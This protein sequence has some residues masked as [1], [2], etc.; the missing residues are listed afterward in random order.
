VNKNSSVGWAEM[1]FNPVSGCQHPCRSTYCYNTMKSNGVLNRFGSRFYNPNTKSFETTMDW[2]SLETPNHSCFVAVK[3]ERY[4]HGYDPTFYPHRLQQPRSV[5]RLSQR[6]F[7]SDVGDLFGNWV[8]SQWIE[9]VIE[10]MTTFYW[11]KY[12]LLTKNPQRYQYFTFPD[13][14]WLGATVTSNADVNTLQIMQAINHPK[15]FLSVEPLFGPLTAPL[16]GINWVIVG[17]Q[18]GKNP[19]VPEDAWVNDILEEARRV[20]ALV[21]MKENLLKNYKGRRVYQQTP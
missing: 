2:K 15:K 21:Y 14:C 1:S 16:T 20:K 10:A 18:T 11:H 19:P 6:V 5:Q 7:V 13:N 12:F 8:P 3:G 4:P 17:A 9:Q